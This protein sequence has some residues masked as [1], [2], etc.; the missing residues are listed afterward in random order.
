MGMCFCRHFDALPMKVKFWPFWGHAAGQSI[1]YVA[2]LAC[3]GYTTVRRNTRNTR[4]QGAALA[5]KERQVSTLVAILVANW[6]FPERGIV[7]NHGIR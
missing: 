6:Q 1:F 4:R 7:A 3:L 2:I 5:V